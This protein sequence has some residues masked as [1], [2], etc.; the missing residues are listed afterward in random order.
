MLSAVNPKNLLLI[1]GAGV[2]VGQAGLPAVQVAVIIAVFTVPPACTIAV[3]V[4][5]F[6]TSRARATVWLID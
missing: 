3:P 5:V 4:G 2:V 6:A 1:L